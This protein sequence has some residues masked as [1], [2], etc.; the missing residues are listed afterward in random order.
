MR[1]GRGERDPGVRRAQLV[2]REH[3][4]RTARLHVEDG[5]Q[6]L[7]GDR[8]ALDVPAW[9]T[10]AE[11]RDPGWLAGPFGAPDQSVQRVL[12]P[13][14]A[15]VAAALRGQ[16]GHLGGVVPRR[17][18]RP[19]QRAELRVGRL[20]EV[21]VLVQVVQRAA[22][23]HPDVEPL[24]DRQRL[25]RSDQVGGR[26]DAQRLHVGAVALDLA[27]G[28][29]A[30]VLA[31]AGGPFQQ[32]VVDVGD[33]LDVDHGV[34]GGRRYVRGLGHRV[35]PG[36]DQQVPG[37]VGGGVPDVRRVVGGDAA[38]V[39]RGHRAGRGQYQVT[40]GRV[41][42]P[43]RR[44]APRK[45]G[46]ID[47]APGIHVRQVIVRCFVPG[48]GKD[49]ETPGFI[50]LGQRAWPGGLSGSRFRGS[51]RRRPRRPRFPRCP[52]EPAGSPPETSR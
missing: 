8:G 43:G 42:H 20:G 39:Q 52:A 37:G 36:P 24:D 10:A 18:A 3:Q 5:A 17:G 45:H 6:V 22:V 38:G 14:P 19:G 32:R 23:G 26:Q 40:R 44:A 25:H 47:T 50:P 34:P 2:V 49:G 48:Q 27:A 51:P 15:G 30:P 41:V 21:Q 4:V 11:P 16:L 31:V 29:L 12:L 46:N 9:P 13:R 35:Q 33:V 7:G 28:Q 1:G